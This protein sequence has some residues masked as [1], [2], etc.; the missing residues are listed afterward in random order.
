[1]AK[2]ERQAT[3]VPVASPE[4]RVRA[5]VSRSCTIVVT[6]VSGSA[7]PR[8]RR[9]ATRLPSGEIWNDRGTPSVNRCVLASWAGKLSITS[10][11]L[12]AGPDGV[13]AIGK[14][15]VGLGSARHGRVVR[16][17]RMSGPDAGQ[18]LL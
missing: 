17:A 2:I 4:F 16:L 3:R 10:L 7:P 18:R 8:D 6:Q 9:N 15:I 5:P 13:G 1:M 12:S 14:F 11:I